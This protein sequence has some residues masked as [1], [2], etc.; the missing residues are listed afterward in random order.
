MASTDVHEVG[1]GPI[2]V[3]KVELTH[4]PRRY[5]KNMWVSS[6]KFCEYGA[7]TDTSPC[8]T[9]RER[10]TVLKALRIDRTIPM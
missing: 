10:D 1:R 2:L 9:T 6:V 8:E 5:V 7:Q 4:L 3:A